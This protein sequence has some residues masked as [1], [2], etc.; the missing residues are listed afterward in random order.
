MEGESKTWF[1]NKSTNTIDLDIKEE[2]NGNHEKDLKGDEFRIEEVVNSEIYKIEI[3][4]SKKWQ[5]KLC[6]KY[7]KESKRTQMRH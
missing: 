5:D 1:W 6:G 2:E 7:K 3:K 4:W